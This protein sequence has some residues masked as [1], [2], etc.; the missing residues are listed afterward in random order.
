MRFEDVSDTEAGGPARL[1][2]EDE[3]DRT[4][5]KDDTGEG[6]VKEDGEK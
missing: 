1:M 5:M 6:M 3:E 4:G 2:S